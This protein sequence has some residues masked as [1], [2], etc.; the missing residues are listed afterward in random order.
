[1]QFSGTGNTYYIS[2]LLR[3]FLS[4]A[5]ST[6][7]LYPIEKISDPNQIISKC[8][9]LGIG[10]PIY[11]SDIPKPVRS[12]IERF[13]NFQ[14]KRAFV[15]CTQ[16]MYSGDGAAYVA[17]MLIK[18]GFSVRQLA[19]FNMPNN[20]TDYLNFLPGFK[21]SVKFEK[22]KRRQAERFA[23]L[24][25]HDRKRL[26][27]MNIFSNVLGLLQRFPF[28]KFEQSMYDHAIKIEANC[29]G[30]GRC[31]DL[32]P[33]DN[34][35]LESGILKENNRCILCY[36]CINHCPVNALHTSKNHLTKHPY[37]GPVNGFR[38]DDVMKE[39]LSERT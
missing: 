37:Q 2:N 39:I 14:G 23:K 29:I 11:G 18:K 19:H 1:M 7:D 8:D 21:P 34:L 31:V 38:I 13:D 10:Y 25:L 32:C 3:D 17:K 36:R 30:C 6:V 26:K 28:Q 35:T 4:T 15:F 33:V 12:L 22:R 9:L 20:L 16:L 27:G 24:I 5:Q